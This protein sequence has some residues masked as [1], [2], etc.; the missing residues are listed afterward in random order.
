M[1]KIERLITDFKINREV[2]KACPKDLKKELIGQTVL[3]TNSV[4]TLYKPTIEYY[5]YRA[6]LEENRKAYKKELLKKTA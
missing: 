6:K 5:R 2:A 3:F 1:N 4:I